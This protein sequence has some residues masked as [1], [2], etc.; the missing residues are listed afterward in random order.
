M[1]GKNDAAEI[2]REV[3]QTQVEMG[4]TVQ[5]LEEKMSP[6]K[7]AQSL[8]SD[9]NADTTR[10]AWEVVRESPLPAALIAAGTVW[11]LATSRAPLIARFRNEV[12]SRIMGGTSSDLRARSEEP[13]PIG[14]PPE[15]GSEFD[16]RA[17]A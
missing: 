11:L 2:E 14:P 4:E 8:L 16:R 13:A 9:D 1:A 10:Q 17:E 3:E 12:K 5:K 7:M 15:T 6:R